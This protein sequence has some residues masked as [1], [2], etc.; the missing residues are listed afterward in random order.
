MTLAQII[1]TAMMQLD[2]D[3]Q[4]VDD[5]HDMFKAY[6][7][8]GY[9]IAVTQYAKPREVRM[10]QT[11]KEGRAPVCFEDVRRVVSLTDEQGRDVPFDLDGDG[12]R[13]KTRAREATLRALCEVAY[14]AMERDEEEP[15]LP[16]HAHIAL[17]DY[18]CYRHL[19]SGNMAKQSRAQHW[20]SQ[21]YQAMQALRP[22]GF[23]SVTGFKYLYAVTD[24]RYGG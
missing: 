8:A 4:D 10:L 12:M 23:G 15:R 21:F 17:A 20:Q 14:P 11:G 2:E 6:A 19:S 22:Q 16:E 3:P 13:V 5:F 1:K 24:A 9:H 7:N 18:I